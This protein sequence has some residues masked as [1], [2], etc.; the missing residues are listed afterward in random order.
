MAAG[1]WTIYNSFKEYMADNTIDL[2]GTTFDLHLVASG[3]TVADVTLSAL[4][5]ITGQLASANGYS[6]SGKALTAVTWATG[7]SASEYRFDSTATVWTATGG[8][9]SDI[10]YAVLVARTGA[11]GKD[12]TNKLVCYSQLTTAGFS[13]TDGNTL[14]IT[15]SANG[16]FE[17]N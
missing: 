5:S 7:A 17:L 14:T 6:Q 3:G 11:S 12:A 1:A 9:L 2:D 15:P 16:Y 10:R 8:S 13:V 4:T